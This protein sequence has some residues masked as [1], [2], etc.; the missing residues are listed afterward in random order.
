MTILQKIFT[1]SI[2]YAIIRVENTSKGGSN[3]RNLNKKEQAV[4]DCI[5]RLNS[6][7]GYPPSVRD[8]GAALGYQSSS[9]VQMYLNRLEALGYLRRDG[10]K[11][12]SIL[13]NETNRSRKIL[14]LRNNVLPR[15][16]WT[17]DDFE[18]EL[19]F[20]YSGALPEDARIVAVLQNGVYWIVLWGEFSLPNCPS[21]FSVGQK[22]IL[23][24][25]KDD[26][27]GTPFGILLGTVTLPPFSI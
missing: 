15:T 26:S 11:S 4:L 22:L 21:V 25:E 17:D 9:T 6:E 7:S 27:S 14:C 8:I 12:R 13:L 5:R 16:E 24:A 1:T 19:P 3:M 18:G 23:Q 10:G 2:I 20:C